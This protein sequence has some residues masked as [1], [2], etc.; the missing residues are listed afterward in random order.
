MLG[1]TEDRTDWN[2]IQTGPDRS[3]LG[4]DWDRTGP[5]VAAGSVPNTEP[6]ESER[7]GD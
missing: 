4:S 2:T 1:G 7:G 3:K 6:Y 5:I